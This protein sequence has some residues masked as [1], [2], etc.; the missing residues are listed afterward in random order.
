[1]LN[2]KELGWEEKE[3]AKNILNKQKEL[4]EQIKKHKNKRQI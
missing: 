2:K 3:K 4:E 1:M